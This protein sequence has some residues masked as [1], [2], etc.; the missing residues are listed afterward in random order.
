MSKHQTFHYSLH[1][2]Q[3]P[4]KRKKTL[5]YLAVLITTYLL[6]LLST[7]KVSICDANVLEHLT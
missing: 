4:D 5:R 1:Q 6:L 2:M 7:Y 3:A